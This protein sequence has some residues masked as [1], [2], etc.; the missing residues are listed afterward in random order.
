MLLRRGI[1]MPS[2]DW[3]GASM[4]DRHR[5]SVQAALLAYPGAWAS[6]TSA[7]Q[8]HG[9]DVLVPRPI[10]GVP[11]V[12]I[13]RPGATLHEAGLLVHGQSPPPT[14][15]S[16]IEGVPCSTLIRATIEVAARRSLPHAVAVMDSGMR[17]A[18]MRDH[19]NV[20]RA[21]QD[22]ALTQSLVDEWDS[23]VAKYTRHRWVTTVRI[24]IRL[25]D[26]AAESFLE[27]I[28]RVAI[29][30]AGLPRPRCGVP[31]LGDD[32]RSYWLDFWWEDEGVIGEADGLGKYRDR[33]DLLAEK[34]R[35]EALAPRARIVVRWGMSQVVP[36]P[37]PLLHRL[38]QALLPARG[39]G[40]SRTQA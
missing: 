4:R 16:E 28:S 31:M 34:L 35:Q 20:R 21:A 17:V 30:Q 32:G 13:S 33:D 22:P 5:W 11:V 40:W 3:A 37:G 10:D 19:A 39:M 6:H 38:R 29:A 12:H 36:D 14:H 8:L 27:S 23:E 9:I 26:P 7:T 15:V 25:A 24:A 2:A 1:V 18:L